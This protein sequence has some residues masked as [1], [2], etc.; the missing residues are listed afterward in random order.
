MDVV[1]P[2][3]KRVSCMAPGE[4]WTCLFCYLCCYKFGTH[5]F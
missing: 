1:T 5:L 3:Q 4:H 2:L